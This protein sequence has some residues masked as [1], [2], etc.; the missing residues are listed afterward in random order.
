L[1][2]FWEH[3]ITKTC[4]LFKIIIKKLL[5]C[6]IPNKI[7]FKKTTKYFALTGP[8]FLFSD[9]KPLFWDNDS[10]NKKIY[11]L[12]NIL[13]NFLFLKITWNFSIRKV[14]GTFCTYCVF[15]VFQ[16]FRKTEKRSEKNNI[17][18]TMYSKSVAKCITHSWPDNLSWQLGQ[19]EK[20][21]HGLVPPTAVHRRPWLT[22]GIY[23][24]SADCLQ[25]GH[26]L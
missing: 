12:T 18:T 7:H 14:A 15:H 16:M 26:V 1:S 11:F 20:V 10:G 24:C 17:A 5:I 19:P 4:L 23:S 6:F 13:T 21:A 8:F 3:F 2:F 22:A 9:T 25:S